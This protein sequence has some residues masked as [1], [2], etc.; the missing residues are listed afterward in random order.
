M[1]PKRSKMFRNDRIYTNLSLKRLTQDHQSCKILLLELYRQ[2]QSTGV[3]SSHA[4]RTV[5]GW[6]YIRQL[7]RHY[8][9]EDLAQ[10]H[11]SS[12]ITWRCGIRSFL[13]RST[14]S[15]TGESCVQKFKQK[16]ENFLFEK[17]LARSPCRKH[18][19]SSCIRTSQTLRA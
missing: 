16:T 10:N 13:T 8:L 7:Q 3:G 1:H 5:Q 14:R 17:K 19:E 4:K 6:K 2:T 11:K 15:R 9:H 18:T 12:K